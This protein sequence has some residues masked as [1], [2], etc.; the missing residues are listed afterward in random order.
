MPY[1]SMLANGYLQIAYGISAGF[2]RTI[3]ASNISAFLFGGF[4]C[5]QFV[6][7]SSGE[8]PLTPYYTGVAATFATVTTLV[9]TCTAKT[10][11]R[12]L[13]YLS[14]VIAAAFFGGPLQ[15]IGDVIKTKSTRNLPFPMAVATC[16]N[17]VL[18]MGYGTL[19]TNDPFV[20][21]PNAVGF[22][23]SLVQLFLF[24]VYGIQRMDSSKGKGNT[25]K[26]GTAG[27]AAVAQ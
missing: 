6:R 10:A 3:I 11:Q 19:V 2:D 14:L 13:G 5:S 16:I 18:W 8:F 27:K 24:A 23:T 7:Y 26:A 15:A 9:A 1:F 21:G 20:Y 17:S 22:S 4:Y 12:V 25:G